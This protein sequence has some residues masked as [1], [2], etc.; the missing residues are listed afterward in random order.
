[1]TAAVA[2]TAGVVTV[3]TMGIDTSHLGTHPARMWCRIPTGTGAELVTNAA[4]D[5][6]E[7]VQFVAVERPSGTRVGWWATAPLTGDRAAVAEML[8]G[9][10]DAL[11][12]EL[13]RDDDFGDEYVVPVA[14]GS[15]RI[16]EAHSYVRVV[17]AGG[18]GLSEGSAYW[19]VDEIA[20][21]PH[22]VWGAILGALAQLR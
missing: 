15:L 19:T 2:V 12:A 4:E 3:G 11:G 18:V 14:R 17:D 1:M 8:V 22:L 10:R 6:P 5:L 7:G 16:C 20:E 21:D 13:G 9:L